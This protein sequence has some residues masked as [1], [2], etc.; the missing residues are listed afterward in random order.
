MAKKE[1]TPKANETNEVNQVSNSYASSANV[2]G[3]PEALKL[4]DYNIVKDNDV[5]V[6]KE[7]LTELTLTNPNPARPIY[8]IFLPEQFE[9]MGLE[10]KC[11]INFDLS[12]KVFLRMSSSA[13][14]KNLVIKPGQ[15]I[16]KLC[17]VI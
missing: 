9:K 14:S 15:T 2:L 5:I 12:D 11:L 3:S 6:E 10:C 16:M 13:I 17:P 1:T 8:M 4:V 7:R